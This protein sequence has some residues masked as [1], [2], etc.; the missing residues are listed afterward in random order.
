LWQDANQGEN[1]KLNWLIA[2][3]LAM[4]ASSA[5]A[6]RP[7]PRDSVKPTMREF[8]QAL[9]EF[10]R[11]SSIAAFEAFHKFRPKPWDAQAVAFLERWLRRDCALGAYIPRPEFESQAR[12]LLESG[13]D[14]PLVHYMFARLR[15]EDHSAWEA[16]PSLQ[17]AMRQ[18]A[19]AGYPLIW[20]ARAKYAAGK[21][22]EDHHMG[23]A[24]SYIEDAINTFIE[25]INA[26]AFPQSAERFLVLE[27][28]RLID[29]DLP[30][31]LARRLVDAIEKSEQ[32]SQWCKR[33][34][35]GGL[36]VRLGW[37]AR[38]AGWAGE[39]KPEG[40]EGLEEH[41]KIALRHLIV[42]HTLKP[43]Y[44]EAA[45]KMITIA[46]AGHAPDGQDERYW[47]DLA[48]EAQLDWP[49]AYDRYRY[50]MFPRWGGSH[51]QMYAFGME[52]FDTG[53]FDTDV[54]YQ[55]MY[56]LYHIAGDIQDGIMRGS[57]VIDDLKKVWRQPGVY[58]NAIVLLE[59]MIRNPSARRSP[60]F[61]I[62]LM[63]T[64][65]WYAGRMEDCVR[66][67]ERNRWVLDQDAC[68]RLEALNLDIVTDAAIFKSPHRSAIAEAQ[69]AFVSRDFA[70]AATRYEQ[71]L[72]VVVDDPRLGRIVQ[73]RAVTSAWM[74]DF[75]QGDW[76]ALN[77]MEGMPGWWQRRGAWQVVD[78]TTVKGG[79]TRDGLM[80]ACKAPFGQR[81]EVQGLFYTRFMKASWSNVGVFFNAN[82]LAEN[83]T[84]QSFIHETRNDKA[85]IG[86]GYALSRYYPSIAVQEG[87]TYR[88]TFHLRLWDGEAALEI[89]G[90]PAFAG[91][92]P[93]GSAKEIGE[94]L[95]IGGSYG[96]TNGYA[97]FK[98][99]KVRKLVK[100][101]AEIDEWSRLVP[102]LKGATE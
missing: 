89:N 11:S 83:F 72:A 99:F 27:M 22:R 81:L 34:L 102:Q 50:A 97:S 17:T 60:E 32:V 91:R 39:V 2:T 30:S 44:P 36:H 63:A 67:L 76:V 96:A 9:Y 19:D 94:H 29:D 75:I 49:D 42:A 101:P 23:D 1:V 57:H 33:T 74:R 16:W 87:S 25:A 43:E 77:F 53:R 46:M 41:L 51:G 82:F 73:D 26:G 13:C 85:R 70:A 59:T 80:L 7:L 61:Y 40:W 20:E 68:R 69:S 93:V 3:L 12:L 10:H 78:E 35:Q 62:A 58:E 92:V 28:Q 79:P 4:V 56:S 45:S 15:M 21:L 8:N 66:F 38:G 14:D 86:I 90:K 84:G 71:L 24:P 31:E 6:Q 54:P 64:G 88:N 52:C 95:A 100:R 37:D 98:D 5:F 65:A 48:V 55:F 18:F 47:F